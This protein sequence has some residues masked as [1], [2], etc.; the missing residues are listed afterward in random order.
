ML[1][2]GEIWKKKAQNVPKVDHLSNLKDGVAI[3]WDEKDGRREVPEQKKFR[4]RYFKDI[5]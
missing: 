4:F 1:N 3:N 2:F 5:C